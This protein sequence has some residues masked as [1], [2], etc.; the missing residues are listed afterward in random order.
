MGVCVGGGGGGVGQK[1]R[2]EAAV[3]VMRAVPF[4]ASA[5]TSRFGIGLPEPP[6]LEK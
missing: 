5:W 4:P 2:S 3:D 1:G 6:Q